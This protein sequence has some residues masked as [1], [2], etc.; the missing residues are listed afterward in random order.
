MEDSDKLYKHAIFKPKGI[1]MIRNITLLLIFLLLIMVPHSSFAD[2]GNFGQHF[3]VSILMGAIGETTIHN[4]ENFNVPMKILAGTVIGTVPGLIKEIF[5]SKEK[6]NHFSEEQLL[7]DAMGSAVGSFIA[8]KF[9]SRTK[10]NVSKSD[11]GAK[12]SF[13]YHY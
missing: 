7:Y 5:D 6:N 8:Y 11:G 1:Y 2:D 3:T 4:R 12:I 10:V 9:N 13:L